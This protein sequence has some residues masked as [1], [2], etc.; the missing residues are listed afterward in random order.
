MKRCLSLILIL[1]LVSVLLAGCAGELP[2]LPPL[3]GKAD[4]SPAAPETD[5]ADETPAPAA[6][7]PKELALTFRLPAANGGDEETA[8]YFSPA[9]E[10]DCGFSYPAYC[11]QWVE[12]G[13]VRFDPGWFFARMFFTSVLRDEEDAPSDLVAM[14]EPGKWG[15]S[16]VEGTVGSGE[17]YALRMLHL[18]YDTWRDWI[19]W[20]TPDRY[21]LLYGACFDGREE[22]VGAIFETIA[23]SFLTGGEMLVSAP[24]AGETLA[25][26]ASLAIGYEGAS[27]HSTQEGVFLELSLSVRN[28]GEE[29][30]TLAVSAPEADGRAL[31]FADRYLAG[32]HEGGIWCLSL[33]LTA[34][35][36]TLA[37]E[38]SFSVTAEGSDAPAPLPV[39]I[40]ITQ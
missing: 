39:S 11:T 29:A 7:E 9:G 1:C 35:D 27:L 24:E 18:K 21:Y 5:E 14:I 30:Y 2:S 4:A 36:G 40:H 33:P 12:K 34:E 26:N 3:P 38:L 37:K 28:A 19:A 25:E 15:A 6:A 16:P 22:V 8:W 32:G 20:E 23:A 13:A 10:F 17:W 31:A